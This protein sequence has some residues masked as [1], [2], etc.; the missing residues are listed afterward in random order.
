[1]H[2]NKNDII[3]LVKPIFS[4]YEDVGLAYLFGSS[5]TNNTGPLSD[6]DFAVFYLEKDKVKMYEKHLELIAKLTLHLQCDKVD[7]LILNSEETNPEVKF[8]V[9]KDGVL[10]FERDHYK[11]EIE[12]KIMNAYFDFKKSL[13]VNGIA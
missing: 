12:P 13:E 9:I 10:I 7:V 8:S 11:V 4:S 6:Y 3:N 5:A 1:M 2:L